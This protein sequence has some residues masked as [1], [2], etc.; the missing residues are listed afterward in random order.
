MNTKSETTHI[1]KGIILD[2]DG[3]LWD[4]TKSVFPLW[5]RILARYPE[6]HRQVSEKEI[7]EAMGKTIHEIAVMLLPDQ[8]P[9]VQ[10]HIMNEICREE[11]SWLHAHGGILY[12]NV[13]PILYELSRDYPLYLVSSCQEGYAEAFL[14]FHGFSPFFSDIESSGRTGKSKGENILLV[15]NRNRIGK[16]V[17]VG[18]TEQDELSA[19]YAGIPFIHAAYGFG[20]ALHPDAIIYSPEELPTAVSYFLCD[21]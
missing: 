6:F 9:L 8:D 10:D 2:L 19:R 7:H 1:R 21:T 16:A 3:T 12:P 18:D 14:S 4:S 11:V 20:T 17:Y 5:N 15:M 13:K